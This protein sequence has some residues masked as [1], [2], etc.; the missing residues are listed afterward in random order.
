MMHLATENASLRQPPHRDHHLAL[1]SLAFDFDS[2]VST[3]TKQLRV[4]IF[5]SFFFFFFFNGRI[6]KNLFFFFVFRFSFLFSAVK[7]ENLFDSLDALVREQKEMEE[8]QKSTSSR[9]VLRKSTSTNSSLTKRIEHFFSEDFGALAHVFADEHGQ[10]RMPE[11]FHHRMLATK[12]VLRGENLMTYLP[13]LDDYVALDDAARAVPGALPL[14]LDRKK[15][16]F[17]KRARLLAAYIAT[18][19]Q[20]P[21][22]ALIGLRPSDSVLA[23]A[24][25]PLQVISSFLRLVET[26]GGDPKKSKFDAVVALPDSVQSRASRSPAAAAAA[27]SVSATTSQS[28]FVKREPALIECTMKRNRSVARGSRSLFQ[29][30]REVVD[31]V[32]RLSALEGVSDSQLLALVNN[33]GTALHAEA[34]LDQVWESN[35]SLSAGDLIVAAFLPS[36]LARM[37][38]ERDELFRQE[39]VDSSPTRSSSSSSLSSPRA[40]SSAAAA[41]AVDGA[42]ESSDKATYRYCRYVCEHDNES[43]CV[44][45]FADE[46]RATVVRWVQVAPVLSEHLSLLGYVR[47]MKQLAIDPIAELYARLCDYVREETFLFLGK[48]YCLDSALL[49][50]IVAGDVTILDLSSVKRMRAKLNELVERS[51]PEFDAWLGIV[52]EYTERQVDVLLQTH[53]QTD[54]FAPTRDSSLDA[55]RSM[56]FG[57]LAL[58]RIRRYVAF[59]DTALGTLELKKRDLMDGSQK[60][61]MTDWWLSLID[62]RVN[63]FLSALGYQREALSADYIEKPPADFVPVRRNLEVIQQCMNPKNDQHGTQRLVAGLKADIYPRIE[64]FVANARVTLSEHFGIDERDFNLADVQKQFDAQRTEGL[65]DSTIE[66]WIDD[67]IKDME[68][69]EQI[70]EAELHAEAQA[71][72]GPDAPPPKGGLELGPVPISGLIIGCFYRYENELLTALE[73]WAHVDPTNVGAQPVG[74]ADDSILVVTDELLSELGEHKDGGKNGGGGD[75]EMQRDDSSARSLS[76]NDDHKGGGK[77]KERGKERRSSHRRRMSRQQTTMTIVE[78]SESLESMK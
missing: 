4:L 67:M 24:L 22:N 34:Q 70:R 49:E 41:P 6:E 47:S 60:Q 56:D 46:R 45:P 78:T 21:D 29:R 39:E 48:T 23:D 30:R 2:V 35:E 63:E 62:R 10:P 19:Q 55:I 28:A 37:E 12:T 3:T 17:V 50:K 16:E 74:D 9:R 52:A 71:A 42:D 53:K 27:A 32:L 31:I 7:M 13:L 77:D 75:G 69:L 40:S 5:F 73:C 20:D 57:E 76:G 33:I 59:C 8:S 51:A 14:D 61:Q 54:L 66:A 36:H 25:A 68:Y 18:H 64:E 72:A 26:I 38:K 15:C 43:I 44:Y 11:L 58:Q 65:L 1:S